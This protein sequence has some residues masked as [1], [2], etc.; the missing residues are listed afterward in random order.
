MKPSYRQLL[1]RLLEKNGE[2][3]ACTECALSMQ[4]DAC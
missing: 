3:S 2:P 4:T 1:Y